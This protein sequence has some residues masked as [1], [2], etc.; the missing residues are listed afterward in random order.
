[1]RP[2]RLQS[3]AETEVAEAVDWYR[4]RSPSAARGFLLEL[5]STLRKIH[6]DPDSF[7]LVTRTLRRALL[8][9]FHYGVYFRA[10]SEVVAIVGVIH[11]RRH[12]RRWRTRG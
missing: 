1:V 3:V 6:R 5:D 2:L 10:S 9:H 12:P 11:G 4:T 7:P 8:S